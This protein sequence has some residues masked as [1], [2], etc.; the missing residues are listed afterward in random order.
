MAFAAHLLI[1]GAR[2]FDLLQT[3]YRTFPYEGST[4]ASFNYKLVSVG[5]LAG[6]L[7]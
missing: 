7:I 5:P 2:G 4:T 6:N 1:D 3:Y